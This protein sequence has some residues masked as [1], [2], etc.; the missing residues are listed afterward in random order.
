MMQKSKSTQKIKEPGKKKRFW[1]FIAKNNKEF[2]TYTHNEKE[3]KVAC[4][5]Q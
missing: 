5:A 4:C 1:S 2:R 3:I